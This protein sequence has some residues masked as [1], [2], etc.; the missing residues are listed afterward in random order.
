MT[1]IDGMSL[2]ELISQRESEKTG[3]ERQ[4]CN[5]AR[6]SWLGIKGE[7]GRVK[8]FRQKGRTCVRVRGHH[9][10]TGR[11]G[12][13]SGNREEQKRGIAEGWLATLWCLGQILSSASVW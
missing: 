6:R 3:V 4:C 8:G 12:V 7:A 2:A 1:T 11:C 13:G 5:W 9:A 10:I